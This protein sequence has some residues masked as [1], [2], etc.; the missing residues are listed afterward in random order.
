MRQL[1]GVIVLFAFVGGCANQFDPATGEMLAVI[2]QAP[3]PPGYDSF[4]FDEEDTP[5]SYIVSADYS[6][7]TMTDME[8]FFN[9]YFR[10]GGWESTRS[11]VE[12]SIRF[13]YFDKGNASYTITMVDQGAVIRLG[14]M[15][16]EDAHTHEEF[17]ALISESADEEALKVVAAIAKTYAALESYRDSGHQESVSDGELLSTLDFET[18]YLASGDLRFKYENALS[19]GLETSSVL[20]KKG[21]VILAMTDYDSEPERYD[22]IFMAIAAYYGVSSGTSGNIPELLFE[23][24]DQ[25]LFRLANL[26]LLDDARLKDG[27]LCLRLQGTDFNGAE[28]TVWAGKDDYLIRK[29]EE[30]TDANDRST[31]SYNPEVNVK[32]SD[33]DMLMTPPSFPNVRRQD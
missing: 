9:A 19:N 33:V 3:L 17:D 1:V 25:T 27:A 14:V 16:D 11:D 24:E 22:D 10:D 7:T 2:G 13:L 26:H 29:I 18:K 5:T 4:T 23:L 32:I 12:E 28:V 20:S 8:D 15:Y 6:N 21:D 31:T 30:V